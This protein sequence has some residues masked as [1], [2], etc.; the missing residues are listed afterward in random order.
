MPKKYKRKDD[1]GVIET[2]FDS[3]LDSIAPEINKACKKVMA[4]KERD[5]R[6]LQK[7]YAY[8]SSGN[9]IAKEWLS[10]NYQLKI[11]YH[12]NKGGYNC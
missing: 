9:L 4:E 11:I 12:K 7:M 2:F 10:E 1:V 6:I 3:S 8:A 5:R